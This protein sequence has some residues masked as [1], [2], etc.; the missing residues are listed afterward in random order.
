MASR[1][2]KF[3]TNREFQQVL[4]HGRSYANDLAVLYVVGGTAGEPARFGVSVPRR[5]GNAV[6]RNRVRRLF[7]AA[8]RLMEP[9]EAG[10][11]LVLIPRA[12]ARGRRYREVW[13][14]LAQL[15]ARAGLGG[16]AR[17]PGAGPEGGPGR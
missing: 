8:H 3:R 16:P 17:P 1:P 6:A 4:R 13:E 15:R 5:F 10:R 14:A 2:G 12:K 7:W 9:V 11:W